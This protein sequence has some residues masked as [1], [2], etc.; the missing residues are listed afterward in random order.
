MELVSKIIVI[1][2]CYSYLSIL[3]LRCCVHDR[4][5]RKI[6][7]RV[8]FN[9]TFVCRP[10]YSVSECRRSVFM[11]FDPFLLIPSMNFVCLISD[12]LYLHALFHANSLH[13]LPLWI[14]L[15]YFCYTSKYYTR[16]VYQPSWVLL[17]VFRKLFHF[18]PP[19][20][21]NYCIKGFVNIVRYRSLFHYFVGNFLSLFSNIC[22][23]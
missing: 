5:L 1:G 9:V 4:W 12:F 21:E 8:G 6:D 3:W 10:E 20:A 11:E 15:L 16:I 7:A 18:E 13:V 14:S 23:Q 2:R 22:M 17:N 19:H